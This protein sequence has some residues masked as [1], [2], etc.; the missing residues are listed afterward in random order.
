[1]FFKKFKKNRWG[2]IRFTMGFIA[3]EEENSYF[4]TKIRVLIRNSVGMADLEDYSKSFL[5]NRFPDMLCSV[6]TL[7]IL[8]L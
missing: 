4:K 2:Q 5:L 8:I 6:G 3:N 7:H 1:M